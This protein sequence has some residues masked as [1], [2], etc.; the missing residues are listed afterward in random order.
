VNGILLAVRI[1]LISDHARFVARLFRV[2]VNFKGAVPAFQVFQLDES[3][4]ITKQRR[5]SSWARYRASRTRARHGVGRGCC[6]TLPAHSQTFNGSNRR[7]STATR[8]PVFVLGDCCTMLPT[9][10][11]SVLAPIQAR[12]HR[13]TTAIQPLRYRPRLRASWGAG[14]PR[15]VA[16]GGSASVFLTVSAEQPTEDLRWISGLGG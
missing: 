10:E 4:G 3:L 7:Q 12:L 11:P 16:Q 1:P 14:L 15:V 2:Q 13:N 8:Q 9:I 5:G 6:G